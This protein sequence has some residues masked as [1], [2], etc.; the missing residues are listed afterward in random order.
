MLR[1]IFNLVTLRKMFQNKLMTRLSYFVRHPP[2]SFNVK[3]GYEISGTD[4][5]DLNDNPDGGYEDRPLP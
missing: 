5:S 2:H 3:I 4:G 1:R